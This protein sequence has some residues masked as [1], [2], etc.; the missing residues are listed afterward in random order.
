MNGNITALDLWTQAWDLILAGADS[1]D[2]PFGLTYVASV[3]G[4]GVPRQRTVVLRSADRKLAELRTYTDRRSIK[5]HELKANNLVSYLFW[6]P[7]TRIQF[8]GHGPTHWLPR[9]EAREVF[10]Q[11][12]KHGR[13]AYATQQPPSTP[14]ERADDGLPPDWAELSQQQTDYAV[15]NFGVLVT[16]IQYA[17]VLRL[18]RE[19]NLRLTASRSGNDWTLRWIVP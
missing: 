2:H 15:A 8:S 11:L 6:D 18:D 5:A 9:A 3:G 4:Q 1:G 16:R 12:P 10:N 14:L 7:D 17:D 13:K 19:Q